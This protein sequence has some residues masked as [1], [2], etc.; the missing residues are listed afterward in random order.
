[1]SFAMK[2]FINRCIELQLDQAWSLRGPR[3]Y[4]LYED[5]P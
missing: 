2:N 5:D 4:T 1:M 3:D